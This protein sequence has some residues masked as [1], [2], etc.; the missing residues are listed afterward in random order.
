MT[1]LGGSLFI[2]INK[3]KSCKGGVLLPGAP[4]LAS[5]ILIYQQSHFSK[6]QKFEGNCASIAPKIF[7]IALV[8]MRRPYRFR[9]EK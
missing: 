3:Y 4:N 9:N 7:V 8:K 6:R 5:G 2:E 1:Y